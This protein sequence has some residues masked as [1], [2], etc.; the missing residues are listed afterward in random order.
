[1]INTHTHKHTHTSLLALAFVNSIDIFS[2][3]ILDLSV[4]IYPLYGRLSPS[5]S[6]NHDNSLELAGPK[7][8][9]HSPSFTIYSLL[10]WE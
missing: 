9:Y 3:N 10:K 4:A 6:F 1:M 8:S 5:I 7:P 2:D